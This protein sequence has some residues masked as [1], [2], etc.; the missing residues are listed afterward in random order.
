MLF[1]LIL[2]ILISSFLSMSEFK[3]FTR[4]KIR[5]I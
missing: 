1:I 4:Q 3:R 5:L 2:V